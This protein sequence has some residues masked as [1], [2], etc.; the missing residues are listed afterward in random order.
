MGQSHQSAI[1]FLRKK[2]AHTNDTP[3]CATCVYF[4]KGGVETIHEDTVYQQSACSLGPFRTLPVG[5][6]DK[7][8]NHHGDTLE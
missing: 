6:C 8:Q 3:R 2:V 4:F 1:K 7:W 5:L